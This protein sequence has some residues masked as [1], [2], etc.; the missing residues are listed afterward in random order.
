[1][2]YRLTDA[3]VK[4]FQSK[5]KGAEYVGLGI[6]VY[7]T[8][9]KEFL[10]E[11]LPPCFEVPDE[12]LGY[13]QFVHM[14]GAGIDFKAL[15]L[16]VSAK[17]GDI[18]AFYDLTHLLTGDMTVTIGRELW[19]E[20]KKQ[21]EIDYTLEGSKIAIQGVRNGVRIIDINAE[22]GDDQGP[23]EVPGVKQIHLKAFIDSDGVG[24]EWDPIVFVLTGTT[25]Y[26][27]YRE[28]TGTLELASTAADPC[29]TVPIVSIDKVVC[30]E[31]SASYTQEQF[32]IEGDEGYL[33][34]V[35]GRSYDLMS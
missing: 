12:P 19:G 31:R 27:T 32:P 2:G 5:V 24:L 8:T 15:V 6:D 14:T 16:Y 3:E 13:L 9:T 17:F 30:G 34:Y 20:A 22:V 29:G 1:M 7:F 10:A 28:G 21:A 25:H 35:I 23:R 33:P 26:E 18:T 4:D 11:I